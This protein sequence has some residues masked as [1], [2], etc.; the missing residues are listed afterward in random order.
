MAYQVLSCTVD[1]GAGLAKN[2]MS[3]FWGNTWWK[4]LWPDR[5]IESI[6]ES[7]AARLPKLM[8][9]ERDIRRHQ[10]VVDT[11]SGEIVGY[12]R[13]IL[14]ESRKSDWLEAQT[15]DVGDEDKKRFEKDFDA[16]DFNYRKDM[17]VLDDHVHEWR[18]KYKQGDCI[19]LDYLGVHP[20]RHRQG[21]ASMLV[22]SGIETANSLGLDIYLV[23]MGR[24]PHD[25][26]R[27]AGFEML[28]EKSLS[29][30]GYGADEVYET[31]YM[32]KRVNLGETSAITPTGQE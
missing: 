4:L 11:A 23:A 17:E 18:T 21:V 7:A 20:N 27:K 19:E 12:A 8:L 9:T 14:P 24:G 1:D 10:K 13:W 2:N 22:R 26:Y 6:I 15:P 29:L 3:A 32:V 28:E 5:T 31:F 16:A 25:L 30:K